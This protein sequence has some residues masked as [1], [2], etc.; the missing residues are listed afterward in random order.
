[1]AGAGTKTMKKSR[2]KEIKKAIRFK[3]VMAY[4]F[5]PGGVFVSGVTLDEIVR[6]VRRGLKP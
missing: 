1:M 3:K 4:N 5:L 2:I 6:I